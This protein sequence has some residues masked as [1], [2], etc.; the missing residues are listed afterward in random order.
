MDTNLKP[1][2][3]KPGWTYTE[4]VV[5]DGDRVLKPTHICSDEIAF[6]DAPELLSAQISICIKNGDRQT[7]HTARV[8]P[9]EFDSKHIPIQLINVEQKAPAKLIA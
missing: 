9:H 6:S 5:R 8:L 3:K 4:I 1:S 7:I 2:S